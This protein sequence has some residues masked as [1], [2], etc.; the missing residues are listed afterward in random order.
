MKILLDAMGGDNAPDATIKGAVKA[1]NQIKAEL[2]LIGKDL[3]IHQDFPSKEIEA[4]VV[5][6]ITSRNVFRHKFSLQEHLL[7][8]KLLPTRRYFL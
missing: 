6:L 1:I 2:V 3:T 5:V 8:R 4:F 7:N